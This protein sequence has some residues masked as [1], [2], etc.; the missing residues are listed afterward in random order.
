MCNFLKAVENMASAM[1]VW[2]DPN[3]LCSISPIDWPWMNNKNM[4]KYC[5]LAISVVIIAFLKR[6]KFKNLI[7]W[8]ALVFV[9]LTEWFWRGLV[10]ICLESWKLSK[11]KI[12]AIL[13]CTNVFYT[14][15]VKNVL[16]EKK[17]MK[18]TLLSTFVRNFIFD[19]HGSV[20]LGNICSF[21][22]PTRCTYYVFFIPLYI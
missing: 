11:G 2:I 19:V 16:N 12:S 7:P 20:Y 21:K 5:Y 4:W 10:K 9:S 1:S 22:G 14:S 18:E 6:Y 15:F 3:K 8:A 17:K 13:L